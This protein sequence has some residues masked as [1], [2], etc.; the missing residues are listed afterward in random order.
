VIHGDGTVTARKRWNVLGTWNTKAKY[1]VSKRGVADT[2][3]FYPYVDWDGKVSAW[4]VTT[5]VPM[6]L[7]EENGTYETRTIVPAGTRLAMTGMKKGSDAYSYWV[8]FDIKSTGETLWMIVEEVDWVTYVPAEYDI[9][10]SEDAFDGF[11][12]AG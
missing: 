8:C 9:V 1:E 6:I 12:Y 7:N 4:E 5:K 3:D 10:T 2:T 11:Y